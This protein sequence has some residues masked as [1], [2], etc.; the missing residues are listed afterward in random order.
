MYLRQIE[1]ENFK[2]FGR[3]L[4]I[5]LL[6]GYTAVTGPN[7]SGKSN[8]SDAILFVL[9]PRSSRAIR[10]GRLSDLIFNGGKDRSPANYCKVSLVFD[11][12]NRLMPI[13]EDLVRL[14]RL[15][16]MSQDRESYTS[17]FYVN[18]K[19]S[20]LGEFDILLSSARISADGYNFVQQGDIT[21]ITTMSN[22]ERR[23]I[24]DDISGISRFD[25]EISKAR[26]E[27]DET[28]SNIERISIILAELERQISQLEKEKEAALTYLQMKDKLTLSKAQMAY[29]RK[30]S[31][32]AEAIALQSQIEN[33]E[34]NIQ[35][36]KERRLEIAEHIRG[37]DARMME[38]EKELREKG[39]REFQELRDKIDELRIRVAKSEDRSAQ[40]LQLAEEADVER[41]IKKDERSTLFQSTESIYDENKKSSSLLENAENQLNAAKEELAAIQFELS[42]C[43]DE[44]A[45][46]E[47]ELISQDQHIR[48]KDIELNQL[49]M[50]LERLENRRDRI[51][52]ELLE[53]DENIE[54]LDVEILD[55]DI[56]IKEL[57]TSDR[58][59]AKELRRLQESYLEKK[60]IEAR[61]SKEA[62]ELE[63]AIR[64]LG[65]EQSRLKAEEEAAGDI[66]R[67]YN[68][69]VRGI[70]EAR[71]SMTLRGV[72]GTIAE[73]AQVDEKYTTAMNIAAGG[74]MQS[75]VVDNDG[76]A[77]ECIRYLKRNS[78]GRATF[79]P[80]NKMLDGR[81]RGKA[82]LASKEAIG[83][84]IDLVT[85][86]EQY[87]AA[88]WYV[89]G[90]TVVVDTLDQARRLMGGIRLVTM[91]G[92]LLEA[93]GAMVGGKF[94]FK[95]PSFG[96][97]SK[98]K[99]EEIAAKLNQAILA[100]ETL[101]T[102]LGEIRDE[103]N[104]IHE[105][106][107]E[108]SSTDGA[109][110]VTLKALE[111]RRLELQDKHTRIV[112]ERAAKVE[113]M[114]VVAK[115][116]VDTEST[117]INGRKELDDLTSNRNT[118]Q[119]R[120][121]ELAPAELSIRMKQLQSDI[122]K[123]TETV[124]DLRTSVQTL[125]ARAQFNEERI[126][127]LES[128]ELQ[129]EDRIN[130][131]RE[132]ARKLSEEGDAAKTELAALRRIEGSMDSEVN[133]LRERKELLF[134]E[135]TEL[136]GERDRLQ[137]KVET[138]TD[139]IVGLRTRIGQC[140]DKIR[141]FSD[142]L[143]QYGIE[144]SGQV[145][146]YDTLRDNIRQLE[147]A[148][149]SMGAIN[150][151]AVENYDEKSKRHADLLAETER[152]DKQRNDLINLE[153][154]LNA[155]KKIALFQVYE[156]VNENFRRCYAELSQGGEAEL[157]LENPEQPF[158]GGLIMRARPRQGKALR[159][160]ALSGG[161]KS[162]AALAFIFALQEHQP[163][164]FYLLDEV[165]MFLDGINAD[166][167]ARR[168]Q[169]SSKTAQF[170][171]ISLRKIT[172]TKADHIIGVTKQDGGIS[173]VLIR[174]NIS[175]IEDVQEELN[176][177]DEHIE[178]EVL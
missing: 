89:F 9:G 94:D 91:D 59:S 21:R 176:I 171:Q 16:R 169:K 39:G 48:H 85:F 20:T 115:T 35:K 96:A 97:A 2:S 78:L 108:L 159:L 152:L 3:K 42:N 14:T 107:R 26:I 154:D 143:D 54:R 84:A 136:E 31:S 175:G 153:S 95:G 6:E 29:R 147:G 63:Q 67:G 118:C 126:T 173:H 161:E 132:E 69:A 110:E 55:T 83:F 130:K 73:L 86:D 60:N 10:A 30:E 131:L 93:S 11:N 24:F 81:P 27:R 119:R 75:I 90:D 111:S 13:D 177:P 120:I 125:D 8:I 133:K 5:P 38:T 145:P 51:S 158:E 32:E 124:A 149:D 15:I 18:D 100:A 98:G 65:R 82:I 72:H 64:S 25:E 74:R 47:K 62:K 122:I 138:T 23:R 57:S 19:R 58:D 37:L 46:L 68:R 116:I 157:V 7:G 79:L 150:L 113:E 174:P 92:E 117:L 114:Q 123:L 53:I 70:L 135:K 140:F 129:L 168:V 17:T 146:S 28:D 155:K 33:Y 141:E 41:A 127:S 49:C 103:M 52:T 109:S 66:A 4:T 148:I 162:L 167:V 22:L 1:L 160:E 99:L 128:E 164:P 56:Q 178:E 87:R 45:S 105:C 40:A 172:L 36:M 134:R 139:I 166:M 165:D 163:S 43:S 104:S 137:N 76:V 34:Q 88:F 71:D 77:A 61:L 101:D 80:L 156:A 106:I 142:E 144:I 112:D 12:K 102:Q 121:E 50:E 170:L 44:L 151:R